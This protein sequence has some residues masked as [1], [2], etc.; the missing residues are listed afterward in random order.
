MSADFDGISFGSGDAFPG[1]LPDLTAEAATALTAHRSETLQYAPRPGLA[2]LCAWIADHLADEEGL[3]VTPDHIQIVNGAKHGLELVCRML[4]S[5]GDAIVVTAPTYF[6]AIPIFRNCGARFIAV[7]QDD[8]GLDIDALTETLDARAAAGEPAPKLIYNVPDFHNPSGLSMAAD[9]R[10][11]LL[12]L[13]AER[14]IRIVE[15]SPYRKVRFEGEQQPMLRALDPTGETVIVLGTFAKLVAPGLRVGWVV[16]PPDM[17]KDMQ[18]IKSDG[19]T[20]PLTQRIIL[21]FCAGGRLAGHIETVRG[22][23]RNHRDRMAAA[24]ATALPDLDFR[25]PEGG[26][27]IWARLPGGVDPDALE[28]RAAAHRVAV[29]SG[30]RFLAGGT[31]AWPS[32]RPDPGQALRLAFSFAAPDDIDEGVARLA[33]A[34]HETAG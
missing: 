3:Q 1:V 24:L 15:D 21:E 33:A 23:Y 28:A 10:A 2:P 29:L 27:Y 30:Q 12:A 14:G 11:A 6:T 4:L 31:E 8:G 17:L 18:Q 7:P 25:L 20:C 9:R 32:N 34:Y 22:V 16:A 19:G 13:A 5:P 26:Y